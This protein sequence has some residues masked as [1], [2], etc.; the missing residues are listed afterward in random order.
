MIDSHCH[1]DFAE[2][3]ADRV[4]VWQRA[5]NAGVKSLLIPGTELRHFDRI[6]RL[7]DEFCAFYYALG[8][9]P[10]FLNERS[11]QDLP[12]LENKIATHHQQRQLIAIGETGLDFA[13]EVPV[14]LQEQCFCYHLEL[15]KQFRL[16][17]IVHHR[18]SHNRLIQLLKQ[19]PD[20]C[21]VIHAFSGSEYEAKTYVE[22]GFRL[23]VG[24]TV[25]YE[26]AKKTILA[27]KSVGLQHLLLETDAP[28]M[29]MMGRQGQRNSPEFLPQVV[30]ALADIFAVSTGHVV[31][32]TLEN[33]CNLFNLK[34]LNAG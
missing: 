1:F 33:F 24:G 28:S 16:P 7:A 17:V 15:A 6:Q 5:E 3:D 21:G 12:R 8:L 19:Y 20:I 10:W 13:I 4:S 32:T 31:K 18:K 29:P 2:F 25:T 23:G 22:M 30:A 9:H 27:I 26:R 14:A 11:P 34:N